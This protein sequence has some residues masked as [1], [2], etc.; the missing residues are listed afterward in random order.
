MQVSQMEGGRAR[1]RGDRERRLGEIGK[2]LFELVDARPV[3]EDRARQDL[4]NGLTFLF[5]NEGP[6]E[7]DGSR[8]SGSRRSGSCLGRRR[9]NS[10]DLAIRIER[11]AQ[12]RCHVPPLRWPTKPTWHAKRRSPKPQEA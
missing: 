2:A 6:A 12:G 1:T 4:Q 7:G 11:L 5:A 10:S 3:R 9:H 8:L